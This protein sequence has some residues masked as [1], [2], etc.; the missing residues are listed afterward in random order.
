MN[1]ELRH[2]PTSESAATSEPAG[3]KGEQSFDDKAFDEKAFDEKAFDD[4]A[5]VA[6]GLGDLAQSAPSEGTRR[7]PPQLSLDDALAWIPGNN[8]ILMI[9]T[10][11]FSVPVLVKRSPGG[12]AALEAHLPRFREEAFKAAARGDSARFLFRVGEHYID[13]HWIRRP[14]HAPTETKLVFEARGTLQL[15]NFSTFSAVASLD[16]MRSEK[17]KFLQVSSPFKTEDLD[18]GYLADHISQIF[19]F[20]LELEEILTH[21][22]MYLQ[23]L[24]HACRER[25]LRHLENRASLESQQAIRLIRQFS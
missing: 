19:F 16:R 6:A 18:S 4:K 23:H 20:S 2:P 1:E 14:P 11:S 13:P 21:Q 9:G 12:G 22:L 15:L 7:S 8:G 17:Q 3:V 25:V 10:D 5:S 24:D